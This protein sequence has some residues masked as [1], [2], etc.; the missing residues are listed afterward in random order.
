MRR[1]SAHSRTSQRDRNAMYV[2][3]MG[4][5]DHVPVDAPVNR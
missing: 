2:R 4:S 1:V 5:C 3:A